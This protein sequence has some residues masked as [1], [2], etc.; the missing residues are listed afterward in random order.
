MT[1]SAKPPRDDGP[2][3][4]NTPDGTAREPRGLDPLR[5]LPIAAYV[6]EVDAGGRVRTG[7]GSHRYRELTGLTP[8]DLWY[9]PSAWDDRVH[10]DDREA[11][12][13]SFDALWR[14]RREQ[15]IVYR[16]RRDPDTWA[17]LRDQATAVYDDERG[18]TVISG[19]LAD[20][21]RERE[22][23]EEA[24]R[25]RASLE[26]AVAART[27]ELAG[28]LQELAEA[29]A[30]ARRGR[31]LLETLVEVS[32]RFLSMPLTAIDEAVQETL[33][34]VGDIVG[35]DRAYV[36]LLAGDDGVARNAYEWCAAGVEP[37][38][39]RLQQV[40][41][42]DFPWWKRTLEAG[43]TICVEHLDELPPGAAAE[44][45]SMERQG[46][47]SLL[48]VP[49]AT[50]ARLQGYVG[51]DAVAREVAWTQETALL[52]RS[53]ATTLA[54]VL[55]RK[56]AETALAGSEANH[57]ALFDAVG[58][59]ILV[60]E[61]SGR[62]VHANPAAAAKLGFSLAELRARDILDLHPAALREEAAAALAAILKGERTTCAVPLQR[63]DG[64]LVAV[65]TR[66]SRGVWDGSPCVFGISKDLTAEREALDRFHRIFHANPTPVAVT[67]AESLRFIDVNDAFLT[68]FGYAR[69]EVVGFTSRELGLF[70]QTEA[71]ARAGLELVRS[72]HLRDVELQARAKDGRLLDGVFSGEVIETRGKRLHLTVMLDIT[73]R[74]RA[75]QELRAVNAMLERRVAERTR[76]LSAANRDLEGFVQ[77]VAHDL[78]GPLRTIGSFGQIL[79]LDHSGELK[80]DGRDALRRILRANARLTRL[81]DGLLELSGFARHELRRE[82]LDVTLMVHDVVAGQREAQPGRDVEVTVAE[83]MRA[84]ADPILTTIVLENLLGNA[85]KFT[86]ARAPAHVDVSAEERGGETAFRVR[87]DG[88]GFDQRYAH[89][90]FEAFERL[91]D[92]AEFSGTGIGLG[93]VR[94]IVERHGGRAWAEGAP[95]AGATFFF[96]LAPPPR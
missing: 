79:L 78:R 40:R 53:V 11:Y 95:G 37:Q 23:E 25:T 52:L 12:R 56:R 70:P 49:L 84:E 43:Q 17:W 5:H 16:F 86:A 30:A 74:K 67:D 47:R 15:D 59:I 45:R 66:A 13:R 54:G 61:E 62:V 82:P 64:G 57:R 1:S 87:D 77:S 68:T 48:V 80:E 65:E 4:H 94:R 27:A 58:D 50:A 93:T 24:A 10:P 31:D 88:A 36:F 71:Q 76:E 22:A 19:V 26:A 6:D 51:F 42:A 89:R 9:D 3:G 81:I 14:E 8:A 18:V 73:D 35:A 63:R 92:D 46:I 41:L 96:T 32:A 72:G 55:Q 7:Y 75:E 60:C 29:E 85:W 20:V 33:A 21:T 38:I 28:S 2:G 44:R 91:H 34:R 90:L 83:G 69:D 39:G